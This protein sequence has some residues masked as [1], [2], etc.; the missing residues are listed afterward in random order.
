M[1]DDRGGAVMVIAEA[2]VNHNG[3]LDLALA[4]VEAAAGAGADVVKFQTF[5]AEQFVSRA[6]K[7]ADYQVRNT[8]NSDSQLAMLKALELD[9]E[10][11]PPPD[12]RAARNSASPSCR[13]RSTM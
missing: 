8:G 4:L 9:E 13:R 6:A 7:K 10:D 1:T 12:L 2:G 11:A 5:R 3:Q